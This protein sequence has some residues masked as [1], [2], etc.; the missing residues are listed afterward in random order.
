[1]LYNR[2]LQTNHWQETRSKKIFHRNDCQICDTPTSLN[3]HHKHYKNK[4]QTESILYKEKLTD[5]ITLCNSCHKLI[6]HYFGINVIK[7]NKKILRI[8]RLMELGVIKQK[9]FYFVSQPELY[10]SIYLKLTA[11]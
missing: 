3:I 1:M 2:Y 4:Q 5:L 10:E 11:L 7:I 6:H 9:A 8:R